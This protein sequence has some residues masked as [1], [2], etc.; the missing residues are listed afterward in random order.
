M[1]NARPW[2][3]SDSVTGSL[4]IN[5]RSEHLANPHSAAPGSLSDAYLGEI[6]VQNIGSVWW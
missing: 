6:M 5:W 2:R 3:V 1:T 4:S